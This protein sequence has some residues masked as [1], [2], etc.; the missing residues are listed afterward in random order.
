MSDNPELAAIATELADI[1][2]EIRILRHVAYPLEPRPRI[3]T[4]WPWTPGTLA[5]GFLN[6]RWNRRDGNSYAT[7]ALR[8]VSGPNS[9][10]R[11]GDDNAAKVDVPSG[12]RRS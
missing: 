1:V 6:A 2:D 12:A 5:Q 4:N 8:A 9:P 10:I 11:G 3:D 7:P